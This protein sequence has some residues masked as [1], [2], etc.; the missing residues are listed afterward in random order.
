MD[1]K[2]ALEWDTLGKFI[3]YGLILLALIGIIFVVKNGI[4]DTLKALGQ[5]LRFGR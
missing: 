1:R 4:G 3:L 5:F 2:A